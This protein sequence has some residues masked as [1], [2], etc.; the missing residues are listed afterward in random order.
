MQANPTSIEQAILKKN[1]Q[2]E[3]AEHD[4]KNLPKQPPFLCIANQALEEIDELTLIYLLEKQGVPF[5]IITHHP[6]ISK[7]FASFYHQINLNVFQPEEYVKQLFKALSK[8]KTN[9]VAACLILHFTDNALDTPVRNQFLNQVMRAV[10][11]VEMPVVPV[12][13]KAPFPEFVRPAIGSRLIFKNRK[14]PYPVTVR[15][16]SPFSVAKQAKF[17]D[18]KEFRRFIQSRIFSLGSGLEVKP[19]LFLKKFFQPEEQPEPIIEPIESQL[20]EKEIAA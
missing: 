18:P 2:V 11:K 3:T 8:A 12:R 13:L 6:P 5:K 16:G 19:F 14:E 7:E 15:I 1:I 4:L 9:G 17:K 10:M 20:I